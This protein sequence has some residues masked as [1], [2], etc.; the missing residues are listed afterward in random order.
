MHNNYN[1]KEN[2]YDIIVP[3]LNTKKV[4]NAIK[5]GILG[6]MNSSLDSDVKFKSYQNIYDYLNNIHGTYYLNK[7]SSPSDYSSCITEH[8]MEWED[9]LLE[10]LEKSGVVKPFEFNQDNEDSEDEQEKYESYREYLD[11]ILKPYVTNYKKT[12]MDSYCLWGGCHWWNI[13][14]CLTLA[15]IVLPNEKWEIRSSEYHTTVVNED[16]TKIFDILYFDKDDK[17]FG[18][19]LAYENSG[20]NLNEIIKRNKNDNKINNE[21]KINN[22]KYNEIY[23]N[24]FNQI[25]N[26]FEDINTNINKI[27]TYM[28]GITGMVLNNEYDDDETEF[29]L[30]EF[31]QKIIE[32]LFPSAKFSIC[33]EFDELNNTITKKKEITL[34]QTFDCYCYDNCYPKP[35]KEF[36]ITSTKPMTNRYIINELIKQDFALECNHTF[37]ESLEV[38]GNKLEYFAGS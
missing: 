12:H 17:T 29:R 24:T 38:K 32:E 30:F 16:E 27:E 31:K 37:L 4:K 6:Y 11:P 35:D 9:N 23:N 13:T 2:W 25:N 7:N 21:K 34:L 26:Y 33:I 19:N 20:M 28:E 18:G 10:K 1:F 5:K 15:K 22:C 14:F 8:Q 3:L 36:I